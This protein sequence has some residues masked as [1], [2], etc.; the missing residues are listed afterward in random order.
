[1][2][3]V[4]KVCLLGLSALALFLIVLLVSKRADLMETI[5]ELESPFVFDRVVEIR[6][7]MNEDDWQELK[8]NATAKQ[9]VRADFWF[10]GEPYP[11]VAVRPKGNS[12]LR[13]AAFLGT[14]RVG[15]KIDFNFFNFAQT[16]RGFKKLNL[17]NGFWDP[18]LIR[19]TI[20]YELFEQMDIPTPQTAFADVWV[21]DTHLGLY[22]MVE[23]IDK[24]FLRRHFANPDGNLYKPEERPAA[25]DWTKDDLDEQAT[26]MSQPPDAQKKDHLDIK[27][28]GSRLGDL[29]SVFEGEGTP[30]SKILPDEIPSSLP[31][32]PGRPF[33]GRPEGPFPGGPTGPFPGEPNSPFTEG[34]EGSFLRGPERPFRGEPGRGPGAGPG[35]GPGAGRGGGPGR[36]PGVGPAGGG[37]GIDRLIDMVDTDGDGTLTAEELESFK[38]KMKDRPGPPF[39]RSGGFLGMMGLKTNENYPDHSALLRF[40]EVLN[41]CPDDS[42]PSEIEKVL[43]V[44]GVLRSLAVSVLIVHLDSYNGLG[45]NYY[46]Y[47]ADGKFSLIPWDLNMAFG[48]FNGGLDREGLVNFYI[49]EPTIGPVT[50]RPL[51]ARLLAHKPYLDKY[52][53]Y[54]EQLLNGGFAE[55]VIE[56]RIDQVVKMIRPFVESDD[57]KFYSTEDF[58]RSIDEDLPSDRPGG[59]PPGMPPMPGGRIRMPP[60]PEMF[61]QEGFPGGPG[62]HHGPTGPPGGGPKQLGLKPFIKDRSSSVRQQLD[63]NIP[64]RDEGRGNLGDTD[65][66]DSF[67]GDRRELR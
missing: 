30:I 15:L 61:M 7:V 66:P 48:T 46:L 17:N 58:E 2:D 13:H 32:R 50:E 18:T 10:D 52:H 40:L 59:F 51:V 21:N 35:R 23:Q 22:T 42:F 20:A 65:R 3:R 53:Q 47:E 28:G 9:Y 11:N 33:P 24:T 57:L 63:G 12:S 55:G 39:G 14:G 19:E 4:E 41:K 67:R 62:R 25:L 6:I 64:S 27:I 44:D 31:R 56:S 26:H 49:D 38:E 34:P 29:F 1:M 43:D 37:S 8:T 54:L 36:G 5:S 45:H 60:P 16:F